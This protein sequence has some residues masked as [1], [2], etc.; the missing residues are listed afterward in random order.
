MATQTVWSHLNDGLI[1][2]FLMNRLSEP[3]LDTFEQHLMVCG[4]C[5]ARTRD[6]EDF[7]AATRCG[8]H[9]LN[10]DVAGCRTGASLRPS[11][12]P[13]RSFGQVRYNLFPTKNPIF[14]HS[15]AE[16]AH[17][18]NEAKYRKAQASWLRLG[19]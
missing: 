8:F 14:A 3:E 16:L 7:I 15:I 12:L 13:T 5:R 4:H 9:L 2:S 17:R 6:A 11:R 10:A 1:E 19:T 18:S